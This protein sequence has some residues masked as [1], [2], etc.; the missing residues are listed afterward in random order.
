MPRPVEEPAATAAGNS[1]RA[2]AA[3]PAA[4]AATA[5]TDGAATDGAGKLLSPVVRRLVAEHGLD[6]ASI[7]GTGAGGRITRE[8]V[9][10]HI[11]KHGSAPGTDPRAVRSDGARCGTGSRP[12]RAGTRAA[13]RLLPRLGSPASATRSWS[14]RRS[15]S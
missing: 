1:A 4:A 8:D 3:A 12:L 5:S 9:L 7:T 10:D 13:P 2:T 15:A 14:C 6:P 11:D